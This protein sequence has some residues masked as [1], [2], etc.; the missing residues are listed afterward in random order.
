MNTEGKNE[1]SC[2]IKEAI[3]L[4]S[5][6]LVEKEVVKKSAHISNQLSLSETGCTQSSASSS[7]SSQALSACS[8]ALDTLAHLRQMRLAEQKRNF[9]SYKDDKCNKRSTQVP[10]LGG[11]PSKVVKPAKCSPWS[12]KFVCLAAKAACRV[13]TSAEKGLLTSFGLGEKIIKFPSFQTT[14]LDEFQDILKR[15]YPQLEFTGGFDLL[16]CKPNSKELE[17]IPFMVTYP[18]PRI[19]QHVSSGRVYVRPLQND[20]KLDDDDDEIEWV[21]TNIN[22]LYSY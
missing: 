14:M 19:H 12:H 21:S 20:I 4:L 7:Q 3:D 6:A 5:A 16:R 17:E 10:S 13:P 9:Q 15:E 1:N 11:T 8:K 2:K 22:K 18:L